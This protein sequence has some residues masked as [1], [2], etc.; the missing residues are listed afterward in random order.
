MANVL[1]LKRSLGAHFGSGRPHFLVQVSR[2]RV[3]IRSAV[4]VSARPKPI[5]VRFSEIRVHMSVDVR[6]RFL[7][8]G[9]AR[10]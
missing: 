4:F 5:C 7:I 9:N 6:V 1:I 8:I 2:V 3:Q 10:I